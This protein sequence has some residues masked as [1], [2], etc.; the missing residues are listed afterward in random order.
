MKKIKELLN[1]EKYIKISLFVLITAALLYLLQLILTNLGAVLGGGAAILGGILT[2]LAPL[3]IGLILAYLISPLTDWVNRRV[4]TRLMPSPCPDPL[5][6]AKREKQ[7]R[8]LSILLTFLLILIVIGLIIYAFA[9]M[10]MGKLVFVS[11]NRMVESIMAYFNQ[12]EQMLTEIVKQIPSSG[13]EEK[14]QGIVQAA[15]GW[16]GRNFNAGAVVTWITGLGGGILNIV[17]GVVVCIYLLIDRDFFLGLWRKTLHLLLPM[18]KNARLNDTLHDI[19][20]VISRFLRGQLLDGLIIAVLSSIGLTLVKLEF[21]VFIGCFAGI[22][23]IIPY[24]GPILGMIPAAIVGLLSGNPMQAVLAVLVL[25][26]IQQV[27]G[28]LIAPRIVG[29][30]IGLH[31]VFV[32]LAVTVGGAYFGIGGMLL[33]VPTAAILKLFLVRKVGPIE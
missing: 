17:L 14:L 32:L 15:T 23:N 13:L 4:M 20:R 24:F 2:T 7:A 31:P 25:F 3:W 18:D 1:D 8:S 30:S 12:Y 28:A 11:M 26:A 22:A 19:D 5:K 9:V 33:A 29:S 27:D 16:L 6:Q 10:I 21:A